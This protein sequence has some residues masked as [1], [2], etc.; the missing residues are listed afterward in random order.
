MIRIS[1]RQFV[2]KA[3]ITGSTIAAFP[4]IFVP[5]AKAMW[6]RKTVVHPNVNNLRV[7]GITDAR[8]TKEQGGFY[9]W[10]SQ[11]KV[12]ASEIVG[13]NI[14]KLACSL[15]EMRNP[16][17]AWRTIFIKPPQK[18]WSDTVVAI[19]TN[20][21]GAYNTHSAVMAKICNTLV[22]ALG[23]K[24]SNIHIYD[25][26]HGGAGSMRYGGLISRKTPFAGLP[27]GCRI[28]N[29]WG[30]VTTPTV[31]SE[32]W[33]KKGRKVKCLKHLVD[34]SVGIL[35]NIAMCKGHSYEF[36]GFTMTMKNHFG[37]FYPGPAHMGI[38]TPGS[39]M[40]PGG[41]ASDALSYITAINQTTEVLGLMD[42]RTG[43]VLYPRQQLCLVDGLWANPGGLP[44][45]LQPGGS[46]QTNFLAMGVL[47]PVVDY[48]VAKFRGDKMG[49]EP[50]MTA[51]RQML[52]DFGFDE[53]DLPAGGKLI[54]I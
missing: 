41:A 1:R 21:C 16:E 39:D 33:R 43:K 14:D 45:G 18:S 20:N 38:G 50:E 3:I 32:P 13:E 2:K 11:E 53:R 46:S 5:K 23:V 54:E 48:L 4:M 51:T 52:T 36:G 42:E 10:A 30:G 12:V 9:S 7:V 31:V 35:I 47:S 24:P 29:D 49:F 6:A 8:M 37:T 25:A 22:Q 17:A 40:A 28:E 26:M 27:E 44:A 19:K 15:T 34:G